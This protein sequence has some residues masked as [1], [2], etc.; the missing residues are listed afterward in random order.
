MW[1]ERSVFVLNIYLRSVKAVAQDQ[2]SPLSIYL[3]K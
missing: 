3:V 1:V 2:E